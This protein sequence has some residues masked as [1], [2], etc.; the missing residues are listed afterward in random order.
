MYFARAAGDAWSS[1]SADRPDG[2]VD[3]FFPSLLRAQSSSDGV[4]GR[5]TSARAGLMFLL[6]RFL[7]SLRYCCGIFSHAAG[8]GSV[9]YSG[10][11]IRCLKKVVDILS[12]AKTRVF[13]GSED[14]APVTG[15]IVD[16]TP[17]KVL[18]SERALRRNAPRDVKKSLE[19]LAVNS[20]R[21][22]AARLRPLLFISSFVILCRRFK[23]SRDMSHVLKSFLRRRGGGWVSHF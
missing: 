6:R 23:L 2:P 7:K 17:M 8:L 14:T 12:V 13:S 4:T 16:S 21:V 18:K 9:T 10:G 11:G 5:R 22:L 15:S 20:L 1:I 3:L 19:R